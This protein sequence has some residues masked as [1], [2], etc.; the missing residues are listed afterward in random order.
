MQVRVAD[1]AVGI[2]VKRSRHCFNAFEMQYHQPF[3]Q[4]V[5]STLD[6]SKTA[7]NLFK[8]TVS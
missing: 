5:M 4:H 3:S 2:I 8:S 7:K 1:C 6:E